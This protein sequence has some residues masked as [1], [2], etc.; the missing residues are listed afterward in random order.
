VGK[1]LGVRGW[2]GTVGTGGDRQERVS[3]L[4]EY[5]ISCMYVVVDYGCRKYYIVYYIMLK[6]ESRFTTPYTMPPC[7]YSRLHVLCIYS[8]PR[9]IKNSLHSPCS[10]ENQEPSPPSNIFILQ[11]AAEYDII[12]SKRGKYIYTQYTTSYHYQLIL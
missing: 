6:S 10:Q 4:A 3:P 5:D 12:K 7:L 9:A 2:S 11:G 8:C 1:G